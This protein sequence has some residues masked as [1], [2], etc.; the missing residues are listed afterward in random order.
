M[1]FVLEHAVFS[2]FAITLSIKKSTPA[3]A[4]VIIWIHKSIK[5]NF[6]YKSEKTIEVKINNEEKNY[7]FFFFEICSPEEERV[8]ENENL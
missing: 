4:S 6:I 5:H 7:H 3:K 8:E 2:F 1:L